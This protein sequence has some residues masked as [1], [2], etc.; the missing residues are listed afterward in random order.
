M[1]R[2][3][4]LQD[5]FKRYRRPGDLVF[6]VLFLVFSLLM[7]LSL[8]S[9]TT[10]APG[11]KFLAQPAFFPY[12]SVIVMTVFAVLHLISG[13]IS[14]ALPGR[15]QEV[16]FWLRAVE[17]AG[18]FMIYVLVVPYLGY[19]PATLLF[20]LT[21]AFRAAYRSARA[22][23]LSALM[24]LVIVLIFKTGLSV[25]VPGGALYELLPTG[26]RSFMLTYF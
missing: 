3:K 8:P 12:L 16:W 26:A 25:K 2:A 6:S 9:Q 7:L 19:L 23:G 14:P 5:L 4:T 20:C 18:W 24:G 17:F 22:L 11:T 1:I 13:L 15:W 10:W 21:L